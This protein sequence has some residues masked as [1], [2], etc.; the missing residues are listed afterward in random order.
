[1]ASLP[2]RSTES[3]AG[4]TLGLF[5]LYANTTVDIAA[6]EVPLLQQL[7]GNIAFGIQH[8]RAQENKRQT[9]ARIRQQATVLDQAQDAIVV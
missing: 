5:Y 4:R 1:M 8:L 6:E 7:A 3:S 2:L 9:D